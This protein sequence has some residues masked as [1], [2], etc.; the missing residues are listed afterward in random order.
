MSNY[1]IDIPKDFFKRT[2]EIIGQYET[3]KVSL[4]TKFN[5][6]TLAVN[7]F[8]G[9]IILAKAHW[10]NQLASKNITISDSDGIIVIKKIDTRMQKQ[11]D[12]NLQE[13]LHCLRNGLAHWFEK[14]TDNVSFSSDG[15]EISTIKIKGSGKVNSKM[16]LIEVELDLKQNGLKNFITKLETVINTL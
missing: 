3:L 2:V 12:I 6:V 5:D 8:F 15:S 16:V 11:S 9:I 14:N 10:Y 7:C 4:G 13:I 1:S